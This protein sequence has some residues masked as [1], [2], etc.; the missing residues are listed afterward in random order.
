M[1][2]EQWIFINRQK[3][4]V[5]SRIPLLKEAH[6]IIKQYDRHP[7]YVVTGVVLPVLINQKM[8][9]Y[10]KEIADCCGIKSELTYHI[11]RHKFATT[12]TLNNGVP[13]ETVSKMLGHVTIKQ[14]QHYAKTLDFKIS[15]DMSKLKK[16]LIKK[17]AL[18]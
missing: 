11:A 12:V 3:T 17:G 16:R 2:G 15:E 10:I 4:N 5:L 13:I 9:S 8:N 6:R 18:V 7:K 1:D 14:T